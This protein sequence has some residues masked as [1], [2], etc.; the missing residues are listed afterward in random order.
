MTTETTMA[1]LNYRKIAAKL[2]AD[3]ATLSPRRTERVLDR[4]DAA[5]AIDALKK[6]RRIAPDAEAWAVTAT[7]GHV[8]N[9]YKYR[10]ESDQ[11]R[12]WVDCEG[13]VAASFQR[14]TAQ[15]RPHGNGSWLISRAIMPGQ[16]QGRIV[17][18]R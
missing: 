11:I 5:A 15:S 16:T 8:A 6:A 4:D 2:T 18:S 3:L 17:V 9:S 1:R 12:I 14:G 13:N 10:A 7:G